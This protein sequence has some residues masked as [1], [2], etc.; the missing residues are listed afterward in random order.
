[1]LTPSELNE[2]VQELRTTK[3]LTIYY[4]ERVTDPAMRDAWRPAIASAIR[5]IRMAIV[6][7]AERA[8]LDRAAAFLDDR[9][10]PLGGMWGAPGWVAFLTAAGP[11]YVDELPVQP[12]TIAVW[13]DGPAVAPYL[14]ALK[15]H[16]PVIMVLVDSRSARFYRYAWSTLTALPD[17][18]LEVETKAAVPKQ[19]PSVAPERSH[20]APRSA[21]G[22]EQMQRRRSAAF[23]R[24]ITLLGR[25][26]TELA[27]GDGWVVI[28][29]TP[30][31]AH[32]AGNA[33]P[34]QFEGRV[35]V[36]PTLHN[37]EREE[38]IMREAARAATELRA[39][40]GRALIDRLTEASGTNGRGAMG[41]AAVQRALRAPAVNLLIMSPEFIRLHA[42]DAEDMT[43]AALNQ[44]ADV[45]V[46]SSDAATR[47]DRT[48]GG[49]AARL[50][51]SLDRPAQPDVTAREQ[52]NTAPMPGAG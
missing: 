27:G 16:R 12:P 6:D 38:D 43:R 30:E 25:R 10:P 44:G 13:R 11:R 18:T 50:R 31:W 9:L 51:F 40:H 4:G 24:L 2:L 36:S 35:L 7:E 48:A 34:K 45:E 32:L 19:T 28:A 14:R 49:I 42:H 47:L 46:L 41:V 29:G 22:S 26:L 33:L 23:Q 1:M 52:R 17:M 20:R 5:P 8:E 37:D 15:Q 21:V 3:V 39:A